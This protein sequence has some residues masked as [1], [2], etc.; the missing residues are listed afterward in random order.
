METTD[1]HK[2]NILVP[3]MKKEL[4]AGHHQSVYMAPPLRKVMEESG[5]LQHREPYTDAVRLR[6]RQ[7]VLDKESE[8]ATKLKKID[9]DMRL[10]NALL[11]NGLCTN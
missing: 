9:N 10:F 2:L 1:F 5:F 11:R 4:T 3:P 8:K 7:S 6:L